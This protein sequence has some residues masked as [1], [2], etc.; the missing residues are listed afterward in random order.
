MKSPPLSVLLAGAL[1][2]VPL[3]AQVPALLNYQTRVAVG[4]TNFDGAGQFKFALV[5]A[6]AT[7]NYWSND[8][9]TTGQPAVAVP[10]TVTRGL[11]SV[12]LGD[13]S[14]AGMTAALAPGVFTHTDVR[15]RVWFNDGLTGFQLLAPDQRVAAVGYAMVAANLDPTSDARALRL[16]VG[17]GHALTGTN[18]TIAGGANDQ[19]T[20][21]YAA[22]GG[23]LGNVAGGG[24]STVAGGV[25]NRALGFEAAV[26]GGE[27]NVASGTVAT[28]AGGYGNLASG[29]EAVVAG[30][31]LNAATNTIAT[32]GGGYGNIAGGFA[33]TVP[34]GYANLAGG[35][36]SLAAGAGAVAAHDGTFV[37]A[38]AVTTNAFRSTASNQFAARAAGGVRFLANAAATVGV[39]LAS[40]GNSWSAT[41]DRN[42]KENFAPVDS[43]AVLDRL[44]AT[45]ISEWNLVSQDPAIRHIGPT[46]QDFHAAF[47]VGED[48]RHIS[49][50]DADGVAFAAIQGLYQILLDRDRRIAELERRLAQIEA[51]TPSR[52]PD[53]PAPAAPLRPLASVPET[54]PTPTSVP[55]T[56]PAPTQP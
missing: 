12:L 17:T 32:V 48:D 35:A 34:G 9:R 6:A 23:G 26:G 37:W 4:G 44:L 25:T 20:N 54:L 45:P 46:A 1:I 11:C 15:L 5:N 56:P 41:C 53:G 50:T 8:G 14:L 42:L 27:L 24:S 33:A 19:A 39:Q 51:Q 18:A 38:D 2:S 16:N 29:F 47:A 30:G 36:Y 22:I 13:T 40:G 21:S 52:R 10:V 31:E 3:A 43:R 7:T 55:A 49:S 28:V